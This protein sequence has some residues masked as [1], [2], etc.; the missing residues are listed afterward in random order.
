[1][2]LERV[3]S[4]GVLFTLQWPPLGSS[5]SAVNGRKGRSYQLLTLV[6]ERG[7]KGLSLEIALGHNWHS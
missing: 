5:C 2:N 6:Q 3:L 7:F 4:L 1:M